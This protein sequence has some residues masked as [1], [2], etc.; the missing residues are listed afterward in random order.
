VNVNGVAGQEF[1]VIVSG[2]NPHFLNTCDTVLVG[3]GFC[4]LQ[5]THA[6]GSALTP[7][8]PAKPGETI[9]LYAVGLG[10]ADPS[11]PT[12]SPA[13]SPAFSVSP[14][15][16]PLTLSFEAQLPPA[17]PAPP[18]TYLPA[19]Q[20]FYPAFVGLVSG[21]VGLYQVNFTVPTPPVQ[22]HQCASLADTNTRIQFASKST[23]YVDVC[24]AVP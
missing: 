9:V 1:P 7:F 18:L 8:S 20:Y 12:G 16:Y 3:S 22:T 15:F 11:V 19:N 2:S 6:D 24:V 4:N 21:Y 17:S 14:S 13:K 10:F 23:E 5:I